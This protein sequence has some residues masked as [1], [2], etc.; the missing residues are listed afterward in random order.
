MQW[1]FSR[2]HTFEM[3]PYKFY[4]IYIEKVSKRGKFY[5]SYGKFIHYILE[6]YYKKIFNEQDC[7][8][9]YIE[10]F[11]CEV[12]EYIKESTRNK[13]FEFGLI[14]F[15]NLEWTLNDYE[16]LGVEK[17][18]TFTIQKRKFIGYID[19]L[20][21]DK[22]TGEIVIR[23]HKTG[24]YPIGK[25]GNVLKNKQDDYD[26]YKKQQYLY[27]IAVFNEYGVYPTWLEWNY[28]RSMQELK[29]PFIMEEF[30]STKEWVLNLIQTISKEK[31]FEPIQSYSNC[32]MLCDV[33]HI[34]DYNTNDN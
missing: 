6:Q 20:L 30:T 34:C 26:N 33:S 19:L 10:H 11:E 22:K 29:L 28:V 21:R 23:D 2:C 25:K 16:I 4:L 13:F 3:C 9:Y 18:I 24:E 27:C 17:E 15:E 7:I 14:F 5:S 1:S 8:D 12:S 31:N 32:R